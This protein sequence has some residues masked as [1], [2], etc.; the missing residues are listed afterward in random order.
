MGRLLGRP[1]SLDEVADA[2]LPEF[3]RVFEREVA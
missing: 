1:P 3:A 2:L